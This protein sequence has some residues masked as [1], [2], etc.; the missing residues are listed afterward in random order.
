V[1][2]KLIEEAW[3]AARKREEEYQQELK[4]Q[5]KNAVEEEEFHTVLLGRPYTVL[6]EDMNKGI[7]GIFG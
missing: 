7:P 3:T 2:F 1:S 4:E 6:A 5:Y